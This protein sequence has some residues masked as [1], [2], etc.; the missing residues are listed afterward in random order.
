MSRLVVLVLVLNLLLSAEPA[1]GRDLASRLAIA[2]ARDEVIVTARVPRLSRLLEK[3]DRFGAPFSA[4]F[5]ALFPLV[6][7]N[8]FRSSAPAQLDLVWPITFL[9]VA[10][11]DSPVRFAYTAGARN[12]QA[13]L[14]GLGKPGSTQEGV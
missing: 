12:A 8:V 10:P 3:A 4:Q 1:A 7:P 11:K 14:Q 5:T 13:F 9:L 2:A 6:A